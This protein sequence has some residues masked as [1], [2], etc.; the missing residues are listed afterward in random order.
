MNKDKCMSLGVSQVLIDDHSG[1]RNAVRWNSKHFESSPL[2]FGWIIFNYYFKLFEVYGFCFTNLL[3]DT[4]FSFVWR[5]Q[6]GGRWILEFL[7]HLSLDEQIIARRWL[8]L[9]VWL[10][11]NELS[12]ETI[13]GHFEQFHLFRAYF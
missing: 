6:D 12:S 10:V 3:F 9:S 11:D 2:V 5:L 13:L 1:P 8:L 7:S 4:K